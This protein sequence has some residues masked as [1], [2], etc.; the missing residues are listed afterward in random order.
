MIPTDSP[1]I[2]R[3]RRFDRFYERILRKAVRAAA[4]EEFCA[5]DVRAL[6][7]LGWSDR[8]GSGAWLAHRLDL[9]PARTCRVLKKLEAYGLVASVGSPADARARIWALTPLGREFADRIEAEYRER[10]V[11]LLL[12]VLPADLDR[13][14]EAMSVIEQA[15]HR[16][17][18]CAG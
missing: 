11:C 15:L 6:N 12:D 13:L 5:A 14:V 8:G 3:I 17:R 4:S 9:H 2:E 18:L 7:E 10:V 16:A 1:T